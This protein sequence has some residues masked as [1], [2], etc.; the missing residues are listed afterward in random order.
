[1]ELDALF[2]GPGWSETPDEVFRQKVEM[3][4]QGEAWVVDGNYSR[5]RDLVWPRA[6]WVVWLDYRLYVVLYRV[7]RRT[8]H[9]SL[10]RER[11]WNGNRERLRTSLFSRESI[12]LWAVRTYR[13][14]KREYSALVARPED[15]QLH[16]LHVRS[17]RQARQ[18]LENPHRFLGSGAS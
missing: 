3:A 16:V 10:T 2:W 7:V 6:D 11:L 14:R 18:L 9:R 8:L 12:I 15:F 1:M 5:V 4:T 17:T 13:R